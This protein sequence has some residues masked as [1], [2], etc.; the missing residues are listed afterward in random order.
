MNNVIVEFYGLPGVGKSTISHEVVSILSRNNVVVVEETRNVDTVTGVLSRQI[1][2]LLLAIKNIALKPIA[3]FRLII[4]LLG[5]KQSSVLSTIK[6]LINYLYIC[7]IYKNCE[8]KSSIKII[9]QGLLQAAWSLLLEN[10][11][12]A[13]IDS[14]NRLLKDE[15]N[16]IKKNTYIVVILEAD[17]NILVERILKRKH[18]FSRLDVMQDK[19]NL[20]NKVIQGKKVGETIHQQIQQYLDNKEI[21][22][23]NLIKIKNEGEGVSEKLAYRLLELIKK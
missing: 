15:I 8:N 12:D 18:G 16:E 10:S 17:V 3:K 20:K 13:N 23:L 21:T 7:Q 6:L 1:I 22:N 14:V 19:E 4:Q 2:K 9:D 11:S 5:I